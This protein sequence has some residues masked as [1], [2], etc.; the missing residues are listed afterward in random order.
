MDE[1]IKKLNV[2]EALKYL[3]ASYKLTS[4][5]DKKEVKVK[6]VNSKILVDNE[7]THLKLNQELFQEIFKD[8][9]FYIDT[10]EEDI[11][12]VDPLKDVEYY[13]KLQNRQ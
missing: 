2:K 4:I 11:D 5:V 9:I 7:T 13:S 3:K 6:L 10:E 1:V 12:E 8:E